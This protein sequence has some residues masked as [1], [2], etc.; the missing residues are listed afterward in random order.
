[1]LARAL[2]AATPMFGQLVFVN[3]Q[4][5]GRM[6]MTLPPQVPYGF[7]ALPQYE[8]ERLLAERPHELGGHI[9]RGVELATFEQ[10]IDGVT[11]VLR[12]PDDESQVRAG[13][14]VGCDGAH[15]IVR[16]GLG[17]TFEGGAFEE[18]YM[19][20]DVDVD[21]H[22]PAGYGI[23]SMHQVDGRTDDAFVAIPLPGLRR[24]RMSML[25]PEEL[26]AP[27]GGVEH[28]FTGG[29]APQLRHIQAVLDRLAPEPRG[30]RGCGGR[31]CSGSATGS[32]T[33]T[34]AGGCSWRATPRTSIPR[35]APRA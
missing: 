16:K 20:G 29:P 30:R 15:S 12:G 23:R 27:A 1:M 28:G 9:E 32:W 35:P 31:R 26:A 4:Q 3:G 14:L 8:T 5:V 7:V 6:E 13:H 19:L 11:A 10:D 2:D 17:L 18:Q 25:V 33:R 24:Y 22:Q 34:A 21:W